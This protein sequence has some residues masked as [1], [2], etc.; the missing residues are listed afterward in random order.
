MPS[1]LPACL[2]AYLSSLPSSF[3]SSINCTS[4]EYRVQDIRSGICTIESWHYSHLLDG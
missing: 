2:P 1:C 4:N 3:V